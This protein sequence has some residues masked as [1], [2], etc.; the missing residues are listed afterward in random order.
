MRMSFLLRAAA[1]FLACGGVDAVATPPARPNLVIVVA[2]DA[3]W[4]DFSFVGNAAVDTPAVDSLAH[5]GAIL[6]QFCVQPVCSPTRAELL[7]GRYHPRSGV[8]GVSLG[9][10][11][12]APDERT[13]A[14]VFQDAGY[15]TGCFGKWH[16]GTQ[17]P[18]HP[19]ARGFD[20]FYGFTEGHW[21]DYFDAEME[22]D[23]VFVQGRGYLAD[24]I[25]DHAIGFIETA[26]TN[27]KPFLC[28]VAFNT[29][30]S[31]MS[32][33]EAEWERFC[34]KPIER[35]GP[36]GD[37]EDLTFTRAA[38]AMVENLDA[39]LGRLLA[40]LDRRDMARD[41]IVVFCSDNGPNSSRWCGGMR[42]RKGSTDDG[43]VRSVCCIRYPARIQPGTII[44]DV[45]GAIDLLP[46][47]AGLAGVDHKNEKPLDGV[48]LAPLLCGGREAQATAAAIADRAIVASFGGKVSVR[49]T[50]HRLDA[51]GRLYDLANDPGQA[52][53]IAAEQPEKAKRLREIAAA[54]RRDVLDAVPRPAEER[55][56]VGYPGAPLTELPARDGEPHG[57]VERSGKA[58]NCSFFTNWTKADDSITWAVDV[59]E[60]G[61]YTAELW[62]TCPP[63]D[64][65]STVTLSGGKATV[66]GTIAPGWD[67]PLNTADDR[68]PR[69]HGESFS[70]QFRPLTLGTITLA[71]G[72]TTLVLRAS[73]IPG[74]SV[75]DICRLV[76]RPVP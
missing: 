20:T 14:H 50:S 29:P 9:Q 41:T 66:T 18:Y 5:D 32:V 44:D 49:T 43:G 64:A 2:D 12:M 72:P 7:T 52:R 36:D 45:T 39:N 27:E 67:P 65:G 25:T 16:N 62:Y 75:A 33:P 24:D 42:G 63:A 40:T 3:G 38:L 1:V 15:A 11:R 71:K 70:K 54:W 10:E 55:F 34:D 6:E 51:E 28:Y 53:D 23:G 58:P 60:P 26:R 69:G 56:P 61:R 31:P 73:T 46:T 13:L 57:S 48:D 21:G 59:V 74:A 22:R 35:R 30:H 8:R 17:W 37:R 68:V 4:G 19:L 47:L 76:L